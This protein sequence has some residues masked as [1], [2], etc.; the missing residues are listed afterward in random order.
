MKSIKIV[1]PIPKLNPN[2]NFAGWAAKA[3][4]KKQ[5]REAATIESQVAVADLDD[6]KAYGFP[7]RLATVSVTWFHPTKNHRDR[8]NIIASMKSTI[9]GIRASGM[10]I[11]D[12]ELVWESPNRETDAGNPRVEITITKGEEDGG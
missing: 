1:V 10:L 3:A 9:D 7:W 8:D 6:W 4:Q 12:D 5:D 2:N 11:D